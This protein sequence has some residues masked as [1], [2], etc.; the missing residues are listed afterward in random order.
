MAAAIDQRSLRVLEATYRI[1]ARLP[2][3]AY[4][5]PSDL[6]DELTDGF[7]D[8]DRAAVVARASSK[9]PARCG[10]CIAAAVGPGDRTNDQ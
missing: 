6:I 2:A 5:V 8:K 9:H 3:D 7:A 4:N 1:A 10:A